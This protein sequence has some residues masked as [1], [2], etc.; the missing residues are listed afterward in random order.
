MKKVKILS[1]L[2]LAFEKV[3]DPRKSWGKRYS[4]KALLVMAT[5][6]ML[7]GA[8]GPTSISEWGCSKSREELKQL[9]F[10]RGIAPCAATFSNVFR[11]L[12]SLAFERAIRNYF[13][14]V[15]E[16]EEAIA[17]DGKTLRGSKDG[18]LPAVHLLSALGQS[19]CV[20]FN[21][22]FVSS[23]TNEIKVIVNLLDGIKIKGKV[24]TAD[25][26]H[27]QKG[28]CEYVI[29]NGGDYV[30]TVKD[31]QKCLREDI[32]DCFIGNSP[33]LNNGLKD[34]TKG[35]GRVEIRNYMMS[36]SLAENV[37]LKWKGAKTVLKVVRTRD[38]NGKLSQET[39]YAITSLDLSHMTKKK[40]ASYIRGHWYI[41]NKLHY[42]RDVTLEE[43]KSRIRKGNGS[44]IF[45]GLRNIVLNLFRLNHVENVAAEI[46]RMLFFPKEYI[47]YLQ[48]VKL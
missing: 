12:D 32:S 1:E 3:P 5:A 22:Q 15:L 48:G 14:P 41:E 28:F 24:I 16:G 33:P 27:T 6:A 45:A 37:L 39:V 25:A 46:R 43:D 18:D 17:V 21:E 30:L 35:H 8:K 13:S 23:K 19:T 9:G 36:E 2:S 42:V 44:Q 38:I 4:L 34:V 20:V 31:N 11:D 7:C 29:D 40:L 26:L 10:R 47:Y